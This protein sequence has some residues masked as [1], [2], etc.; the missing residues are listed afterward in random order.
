MASS[1]QLPAILQKCEEHSYQLGYRWNPAKCTILAPPEDT[2]SYTLYN[3]IL[4]KQNS[5]PYLGIPIRPGGYLHT[6]ELIQGNV[7]KALKTMDEMAM[8][9]VNPADFD[10]LLSVRFSTQIVRPQFEYGLAISMVKY[11]E[12]QTIESCQNQ[13]LRRIFRRLPFFN[14]SDA[15][16]GESTF[17]E[18]SCPYPTSQVHT[19]ISEFT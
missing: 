7:N 17:N 13:C 18:K 15:P 4:P 11:R 16:F 5:F 14:S 8:I 3:T 12:F 19:S 9:G 10:R 1:A 6:Q 2:Q